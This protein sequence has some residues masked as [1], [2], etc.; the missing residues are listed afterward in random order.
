MD[1]FIIILIGAA[2]FLGLLFLF[3]PIATGI[4]GDTGNRDYKN[5]LVKFYFVTWPL[6]LLVGLGVAVM[7]LAF[8]KLGQSGF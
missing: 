5:K 7:L 4:V 6:I 3:L 2:K 1:I 8:Y